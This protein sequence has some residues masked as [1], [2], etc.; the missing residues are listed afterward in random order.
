MNIIVL[1]TSYMES[2]C[3][4]LAEH[5]RAVVIDP[6]DFDLVAEAVCKE[7]LTLDMAIVTHEHCDHVYGCTGVREEF[8]CKILASRLCSLNMQNPRKNFSQYFDAFIELQTSLPPEQQKGIPP[9]T[10]YADEVF[11]RIAYAAIKSSSD[12]GKEKG[13]YRNFEGSICILVDGKILFS[14]DTLMK[15]DAARTEFPGGSS[16]QMRENTMP[17]LESL[18]AEVEVYP[19]HG[20]SF[21]LGDKLKCSKTI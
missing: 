1:T 2:H 15:D 18:P 17:W 11:E 5:G 21:L 8:H 3:C 10:A 12:N 16:K 6:G 4:L 19:G 20:D 14:G 9:F 7:N 13:S